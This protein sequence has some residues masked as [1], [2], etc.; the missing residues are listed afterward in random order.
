MYSLQN[1]R[2]CD[3]SAAGSSILELPYS[4]FGQHLHANF[5]LIRNV[6]RASFGCGEGLDFS[7]YQMHIYESTSTVFLGAFE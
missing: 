1:V 3:S 2:F 7:K 4:P 6:V 5:L